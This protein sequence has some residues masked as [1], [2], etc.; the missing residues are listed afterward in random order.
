VLS[1][2]AFAAAVLDALKSY[3]RPHRLAENPLVR[4]RAVRE[5]RAE[6]TSDDPVDV[7]QSLVLEA[8][9]QL[10]AGPRERGYFR[11]LEAT[12]LDP[13]P[14]QAIASERLDLPFSTYRRHLKRGVDHVVDALWKL[15]TGG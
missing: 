8:A 9:R 3:A 6:S 13:A 12:Y 11:V 10:E 7:L 14:T 2:D 1:E 4:S 15:E 5:A